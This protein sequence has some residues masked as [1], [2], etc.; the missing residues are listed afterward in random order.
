MVK[1]WPVKYSIQWRSWD[2]SYQKK[3]CQ[4]VPVSV[5]FIPVKNIKIHIV[6]VNR[7]YTF[8]KNVKIVLGSWD[9]PSIPNNLKK[10]KD[11][12]CGN[13]FKTTFISWLDITAWL[14]GLLLVL[15]SHFRSINS[16]GKTATICLNALS[17]CSPSVVPFIMTVKLWTKLYVDW[18]P[19]KF[20]FTALALFYLQRCQIIP[21]IQNIKV[22]NSKYPI[23]Q[24]SHFNVH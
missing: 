9:L 6:T 11:F 4:I 21:P 12:G 7:D 3:K 20:V 5:D 15:N 17:H 8:W 2:L 23:I 13:E 1:L 22:I 19:S 14:F 24:P 18:F 16:S 10:K